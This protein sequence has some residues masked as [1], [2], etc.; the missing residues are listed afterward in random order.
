MGKAAGRKEMTT[1]GKLTDRQQHT[2]FYFAD[3]FKKCVYEKCFMDKPVGL[4]QCAGCVGR[5]IG[6]VGRCPAS[7]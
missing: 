2:L 4:S 7:W 6:A 5:Y 1:N 3:Q